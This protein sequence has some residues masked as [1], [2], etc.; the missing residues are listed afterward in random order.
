VKHPNGEKE[1]LIMEFETLCAQAGNRKDPRT[2]AISVP[3]HHATAY[4]HPAL[5]VST[6][7][8]YTRTLNPTRLALEEALAAIHGGTRG[9]AFASGMAAIDAL[10]RLFHPGDHL[11]LSADLY[12]GT[13]RLFEQLLRPLGIQSTYVDTSELDSIEEAI[14]TNTVA[15]FIETPSNPTMKVTDI[16]GCANIARQHNLL[17]IVDNTFMT[18]YHQRPLELGADIVIESATKYLGGHNDVLA[19]S[20]VVRSEKLAEQLYFIQNSVGAVLGPQDAW[21][22]LRGLKTLPVRMDR[23]EENARKLAQWLLQHPLVTR[24]YYPG[25]DH[26]PG[27]RVHESQSSGYGGMISFEVQHPDLV[28]PILNNLRLITFAESLGGVESLITYPVRQTHADIPEDVRIL[29]GVTDRLLRLSVGIENVSD[30][31]NDL[32]AAFTA[33]SREVAVHEL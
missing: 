23:H 13:Y 8:D 21:L 20:L 22:L 17:L 15:L 31:I 4:A 11:L 5:G 10:A 14:Q 30:L 25:L 29:R 32:D 3:V 19:G 24:V 16:R 28:G 27:R 26:H 7:F 18:P 33:A 9:F 1:A 2:G 6:G 12:G